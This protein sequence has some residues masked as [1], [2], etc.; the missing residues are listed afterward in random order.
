L[1]VKDIKPE[2]FNAI[3][4]VGRTGVNVKDQ[5]SISLAQV[6]YKDNKLVYAICL[7]SYILAN[8]GLLEGKKAVIKQDGA[9]F[10]NK[11]VVKDGNIT[12]V[13]GPSAAREFGEVI[14]KA[15]SEK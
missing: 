14:L 2:G 10:T 7:A 15:L 11:P 9:I 8:A 4:F 5:N 1:F 13:V 12:T 3:I 6:F